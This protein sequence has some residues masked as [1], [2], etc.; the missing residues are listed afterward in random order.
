MTTNIIA[1]YGH[2]KEW[3]YCFLSQFY[4]SPFVEDNEIF[5]CAEHYMMYKKALLFG[6]YSTSKLILQAKTPARA[7]LLG[8][9]VKNFDSEIWDK[10]KEKY[11]FN[12][13]LLKFSQNTSLRDLLISNNKYLV[14]ATPNDLVWGNGLTVEETLQRSIGDW[15]GQNLLGKTLM[16]VRDVLQ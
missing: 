6:D 4:R 14:E 15:P 12:G 3:P 2:S 13:N 8:R 5:L 16:K 11:V 9:S 10:Y 1:F 7:K